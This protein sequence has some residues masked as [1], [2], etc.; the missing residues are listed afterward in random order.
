MKIKMFVVFLFMI[1]EIV[2]GQEALTEQAESTEVSEETGT[3]SIYPSQKLYYEILEDYVF[4]RTNKALDK[5]DQYIALFPVG[6]DIASVRDI[7]LKLGLAPSFQGDNLP[8]EKKIG[9]GNGLAYYWLWN[10][11]FITGSFSTLPRVFDMDLENYGSEL[12]SGFS[13]AG[14]GT[15]IT[16]SAWPPL[17]NG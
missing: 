9:K 7:R 15:A 2:C 14:I 4:A 12:M 17:L 5:V 10:F 6:T 11:A 13:L 16:T 8:D 1:P 3:I